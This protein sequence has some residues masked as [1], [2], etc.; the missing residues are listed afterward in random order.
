MKRN[1][2]ALLLSL[3]LVLVAEARADTGLGIQGFGPARA[4]SRGDSASRDAPVL[5]FGF[6]P[7]GMRKAGGEFALLSLSRSA[8]TLRLGFYG[9]LEL[10]GEQAAVQHFPSPD[11]IHFWRGQYGYTISIAHT[12]KHCSGCVLEATLGAGHESEHYTGSNSGDA[13]TYYRDRPIIG[14]YLSAD[15]ATRLLL[16]EFEVGL[17]L[18]S[19]L[20]SPS[21]SS[22]HVG[23]AAGAMAR[24]LGPGWYNPFISVYA[25]RLWGAHGFPDSY[26]LRNLTGVAFP[27]TFGELAVFAVAEIGHRRGLS[28]YTEERSI[29]A[30]VRAVWGRR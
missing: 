9:F 29:G 27:T 10:E 5:A 28:A 7:R 8:L 30:G 21:E 16:A 4:I 11:G 17:R 18:G 1:T 19:R 20:F 3:S 25:E 26:Q 24:W 12:S 6:A 22:Y 15:V 23:P 13:G 14:N 2:A